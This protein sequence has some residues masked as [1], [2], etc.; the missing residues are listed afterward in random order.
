MKT[1]WSS[2]LLLVIYSM[3]THSDRCFKTNSHYYECFQIL[4]EFFYWFLSKFLP[5]FL[6]KFLSEFLS[7]FLSK[8]LPEFLSKF[9]SEFLSD[10]RLFLLQE[11]VTVRTL[12]LINSTDVPLSF[13]LNTQWPF[14]VLQHTHRAG[15]NSPSHTH[16]LVGHAERQHTL[17]LPPKHNKQVWIPPTQQ[18]HTVT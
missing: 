15:S 2:V 7:K 13:T 1:L 5:E 10:E 4:S 14:S 3:D 11:C 12:Q 18:T 8:F 16:R 6:S 17:L 9:L